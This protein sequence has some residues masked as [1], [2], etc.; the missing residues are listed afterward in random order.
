[1][2]SRTLRRWLASLSFG[3]V[4]LAVVALG[5]LQGRI[6]VTIPLGA[7]T[8]LGG[9]RVLNAAIA[10]LSFAGVLVV[11]A[12]LFL[13]NVVRD[14]R[15]SRREHG[16]RVAAIV[17]SY[18]DANALHRSVES[19]LDGEYGDVHVYVVCEPGDEA[20][21]ARADSLADRGRV[22]RL[23]NDRNP[24]SKAAA[25]N[26]AV[27]AT[28][29]PYVGVFDAD[30]RVHPRF[31]ASAVA[32]LDDA[33]VVQGRTFPRPDGVLETVA[34]YESVLLGYL[35][36]RLI[37]LATGF[38]MVASNVVVMRRS[39]YERVGGYD[40]AMLTEDFDFAFRC[41]EASVSVREAFAYPSE[42]EGAH[43]IRDW[44]G[45]RK[46]WMTGY[47]Q[48]FHRLLGSARPGE[49]RSVASLAFCGGALLGNVLVLSLVA[50]VAAIL[51]AGTGWVLAVTFGSVWG[52][53]ALSR[54]LDSRQG[55]VDRVGLG[56]LL[57]PFVLPLYSLAA[58]KGIVDY[59]LSW[60]GEWYRVEKGG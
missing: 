54:L 56:W 21:L 43:T 32:G 45:Q 49:P 4:T 36:H 29:A 51:A 25:V 17:P 23:V 31:L 50:Q 41:Y 27:D 1:M 26:Y 14:R 16:P 40:P 35:S 8:G 22:T 7:V 53:A 33:E 3:G 10:C 57:V 60:E 12:P 34:Y 11:S 15:R 59:P 55:N 46:R 13:G 30:E 37:S 48:V 9:V 38:N 44:W 47:A 19:L 5:F 2:V 58:I 42:I 18:G 24:G 52:V 28:D 20:T 6:T 39:A